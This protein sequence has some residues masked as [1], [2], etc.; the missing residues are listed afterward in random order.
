V[1]DNEAPQ[2]VV[3]PSPTTDQAQSAIRTVLLVVSAITAITTL[4]SKRDLAGFIVY[5]QSSDF[6]QVASIVATAVTFAWGQWKTRHRAKQLAA[7]AAD[8]RVPDAVAT[9]KGPSA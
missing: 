6:L 1:T 9:L 3:N 5:V 4:A 2:I 8:P 7:V